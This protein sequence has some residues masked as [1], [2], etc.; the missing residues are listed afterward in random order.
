MEKERKKKEGRKK[1][2]EIKREGLKE[3]FGR[4]K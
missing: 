3:N 2:Y 1:E 4:N